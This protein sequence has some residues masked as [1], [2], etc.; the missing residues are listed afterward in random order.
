MALPAQ[1]DE[2]S[3]IAPAPTNAT[4]DKYQV[5]AGFMNVSEKEVKDQED[6]GEIVVTDSGHVVSVD[7]A[8]ESENSEDSDESENSEDSET[9]TLSAQPAAASVPGSPEGGSNPGAPLTIFLD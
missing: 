2:S 4:A 1:A 6:A 7:A 3:D 8:F 9:S 5:A